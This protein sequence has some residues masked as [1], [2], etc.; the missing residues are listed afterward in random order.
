MY[1]SKSFYD[2]FFTRT[3][4]IQFFFLT[5]RVTD[6]TLGEAGCVEVVGFDE[7]RCAVGLCS[8]DASVSD[9]AVVIIS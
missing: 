4:K 5:S 3:Q 8:T 9:P 1:S 7:A 2:Y 6:V